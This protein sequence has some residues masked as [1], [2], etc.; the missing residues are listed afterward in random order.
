MKQRYAAV[1]LLRIFAAGA[2]VA[3]HY[4]YYYP[5]IAGA[6]RREIQASASYGYL[7]IQLFFMI[8]GYVITLSAVGRTRGQFAFARIVRLWPAFLICLGLTV[9]ALAVAGRSPA[10]SIV[11]GNITMMP[12]LFGVPYVDD[13]YWS[14]L[15]EIFFYVAVAIM[16]GSGDFVERL[17]PFTAVWLGLAV[18]NQI[19]ELPKLR[20]LL[21]LQYAPYFAVGISL[22]LARHAGKSLANRVLLAV[23]LAL[24]VLFAALQAPG[25]GDVVFSTAPLAEASRFADRIRPD[26]WICGLIVAAGA[27]A[28]YAGTVLETGPRLSR[29]AFALGGISYPLYLLHDSFGSV[30]LGW[31]WPASPPLSLAVAMSVVAAICYGVWRLELPVRR[32][33]LAASRHVRHGKILS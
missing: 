29:A 15:Y 20:V 23:S 22:F 3:F 9:L 1:D 7:G 30:L 5:D 17:R 28:L 26:A 4:L 16:V 10:A 13:V 21:A 12:R 33:L 2:V 31:A 6:F 19:V 8:S 24:S 25:V 14:L 27:G 18:V 32:Q 11:L